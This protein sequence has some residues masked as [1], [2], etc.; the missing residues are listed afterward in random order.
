MLSSDP[1]KFMIPFEGTMDDYKKLFEDVV[2]DPDPNKNNIKGTTDI[3]GKK[4]ESIPLFDPIQGNDV[5]KYLNEKGINFKKDVKDGGFYRGNV[6]KVLVNIDYLLKVIRNKIDQNETNTL[7][8]RSLLEEVVADMNKCLGSFNYYRLAYSDE[9]NCFYLSDD[10]RIPEKDKV[11]SLEKYYTIPLHGKYS[12]AETYEIKTEISNRLSNLVAISANSEIQATAGRDASAFGENGRFKFQDRYK[13]IVMSVN[14][15][16]KI[17]LK[18]F[19]ALNQIQQESYAKEKKLSIEQ[20][21]EELQRQQDIANTVTNSTI[22]AAQQFN[23]AVRNFYGDGG[24]DKKKSVR[25]KSTE[26]KA[27]LATNYLVNRMAKVKAKDVHTRSSALIPISINFTTDGISGLNVG[28]AFDIDE[29]LIPA[30]Y[31]NLN[32][33]KIV[34]VITGLDHTIDGNRWKTNVRANMMYSNEAVIEKEELKLNGYETIKDEAS[35]GAGPVNVNLNYLDITS[36]W[37][38]I[39]T[40][41]IA[42][43]ETFT[44]SATWDVNAYRLGYGTDIIMLDDGTTR[45]VEVGDTTTEENAA[46]VLQSDILDRF[47]KRLV[48]NKGYQLTEEEFEKLSEPAKAALISYCYNVG[49]LRLKIAQAIKNNDYVRAAEFIKEGPI[50]DREGTVYPGLIRRRAEESELFLK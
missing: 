1:Y 21:T 12:I 36:E 43:N 14:D 33:R 6:L 4:S 32:N 28:S 5:T 8:L 17:T 7:L 31:K 2:L 23:E 19:Q 10:Q 9:S 26:Q 11:E 37:S 24:K 25:F 18:D 34:F 48:G 46:K 16:E 15:F 38:K 13:P 47:Y 27:Q 3:K 20:I 29:N 30:S 45:K 40:V 22:E 39:A 49:S 44:R 41:Y 35:K 42:K 50:T